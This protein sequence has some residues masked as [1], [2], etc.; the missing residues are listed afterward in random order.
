MPNFTLIASSSDLERYKNHRLAS[1]NGAKALT[2][3]AFLEE[4][5]RA[6]SFPE[7]F[8]YNLDSLD[9]MLNDLSWIITRHVTIHLSQFDLLLS[10]EKSE[11]K[12]LDL[13]N[14]LDATAEDWK[15]LDDDDDTPPKN[16]HIV[17]DHHARAVAM[18]EKEGIGYLS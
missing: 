17:I 11:N 18:L 13:L 9:D 14:L 16:L 3:R 1:I 6:L 2:M 12:L 4:I 5:A 7:D 15:W 10:Q 8:E